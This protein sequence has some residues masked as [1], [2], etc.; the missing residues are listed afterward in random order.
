MK[1][2]TWARRRRRSGY[3]CPHDPKIDRPSHGVAHTGADTVGRQCH[4]GSHGEPAGIAHDAEPAALADRFSPAVA[5]GRKHL[6][7]GQCAMAPVASFCGTESVQHWRLQ[8]AAVPGAQY[9][10]AHQCDAGGRQH[11][12]LDA[13]LW[14]GLFRTTHFCAA[15]AGGRAV[16]RRCAAG[17]MPGPMGGVAATPPG[18]RRHLHSA[19]VDGLGLLQLDAGTPRQGRHRAAGQLGHVSTGPGRLRPGVV[20]WFQC[21]RMGAD[22]RPH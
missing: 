18:R 3:I 17:V 4:R 13:A 22:A 10:D 12:G 20:S 2:A 1:C 14:Q 8:R 6:A 11:T 5:A 19:G 16:H 7:P 21:R 9:V 15:N